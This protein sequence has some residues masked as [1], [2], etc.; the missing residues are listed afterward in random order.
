MV[1]WFT[2]ASLHDAPGPSRFAP[3]AVQARLGWRQ[4]DRRDVKRSIQ[5]VELEADCNLAAWERDELNGQLLDALVGFL[6]RW[7]R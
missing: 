7:V 3:F 5:G 2:L 1:Q 6:A 4:M